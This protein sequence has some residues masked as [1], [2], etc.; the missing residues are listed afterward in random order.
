M[1]ETYGMMR[2]KKLLPVGFAAF[3]LLSGCELVDA[4]EVAVSGPECGEFGLPPE[5]AK[6]NLYALD[7][8][9]DWDRLDEMIAVLEP[10]KDSH[11]P[12]VLFSLGVSYVRKAVTRSNDPAYFRRGVRLF[13]WAAL[14]G[15]SA[16]VLML[17]GVYREGFP[18]IDKDPELAACLDRAY[19]PHKHERA[20]IP[21]RV[22]GCG[23][24]VEDFPE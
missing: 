14:C 7:D 17:S 3:M 20:L 13:H 22:W 15:D 24:R 8:R 6:K 10:Y 5:L 2:S 23:L 16:A 9:F 21:G 11:G 1:I 19:N 12:D 18:G 4:V